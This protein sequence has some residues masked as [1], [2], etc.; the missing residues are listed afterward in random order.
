MFSDYINGLE[1]TFTGFGLIFT[2]LCILIVSFFV[3][4]AAG[5]YLFLAIEDLREWSKRYI[6]NR[7]KLKRIEQ[8]PFTQMVK[9]GV[10][11]KDIKK[12]K[13][14][15]VKIDDYKRKTY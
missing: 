3:L 2:V 12:Y 9:M 7:R 1:M 14:V 11:Q 5:T 6:S 10:S 8:D 15:V 13:E 4:Y